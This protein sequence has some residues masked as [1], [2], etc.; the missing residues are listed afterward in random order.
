MIGFQA[1]RR[2]GEVKVKYMGDRVKLIGQAI[3]VMHGELA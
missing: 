2:G 1:S 3:T